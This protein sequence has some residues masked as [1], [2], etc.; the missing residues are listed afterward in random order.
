MNCF[1]KN[2]YIIRIYNYFIRTN[3]KKKTQAIKQLHWHW[4]AEEQ[5]TYSLLNKKK[6]ELSSSA[7]GV[8]QGRALQ[9]TAFA[10]KRE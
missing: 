6:K 9:I 1:E 2:K 8:F 4:A 5:L 3:F 10:P 7:R